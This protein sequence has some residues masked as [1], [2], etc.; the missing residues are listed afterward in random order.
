[1]SFSI[2]L[3]GKG[4]SGKTSLASL[5]IRY[6]KK[7]NLG[8]ILA[9]DADPNA[10][11]GESLGLEVRQTVGS[12][13]ASFN[14][15]KINIPPGMTKEAYLEF[16]LNEALVES[17]DIDLL[18]MGRGE[19]AECYCY[20]N[21]ILRKFA[22]SLMGNYP[23]TV[24]DNEAGMEHLSRRTTDNV[25]AL[26]IVSNHSVKGVRT[27]ARIK[28]LV[29]ELKLVVGQELV[30]VNMAPPRLDPQ[31]SEEL[32]RLGIEPAALVP[33]DETIYQYDLELKP[34]LELPDTSKAV[35]AI[36]ELMAKVLEKERNYQGLSRQE[37]IKT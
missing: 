28:E 14:E 21:L 36:D 22:D 19:G 35:R 12:I 23:F 16:R 31:V 11:L 13:I 27:V 25:D 10:N 9:I 33:E 1:L 8:P 6:L 34:L 29:A 5:V 37:H 30:V 15:E 26:L 24:M 20:P 18:T 2:A 7:N 32:A 4:G 17:K 3:S